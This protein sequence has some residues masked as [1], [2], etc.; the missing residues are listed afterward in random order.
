MTTSTKT[1]VES[2]EGAALI[3]VCLLTPFLRSRRTRW[4]ATETELDKSMPGD[5][6]VPHPKW[7]YTHAITID[8]PIGAVWQ[9]LVQIGQGRGGLYSYDGLEN[10]VGCDMHSAEEIVPELQDLKPGDQVR[11]HPQMPPL[12]VVRVDDCRVIIL[13][14]GSEGDVKV[15]WT[16]F[17]CDIDETTTRF[18]IR[19]R[20]DFGPTPS[21]KLGYGPLLMEPIS[22]VME[23]KLMLGLKQRAEADAESVVREPAW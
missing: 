11:L 5:D 23:R 9:W 21:Q 4:G 15:S 10:L 8:A 2:I 12:E 14:G 19:W 6:L 18:V 7:H 17:L 16:F 3:G 1:F 22:F 20:S 13:R